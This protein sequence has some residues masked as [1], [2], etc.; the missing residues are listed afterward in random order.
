MLEKY[1]TLH[2]TNLELQ[3]NMDQLQRQLDALNAT[4]SSLE[5]QI[6]V[7]PVSIN[8]ITYIIYNLLLIIL[9]IFFCA[10]V[11]YLY[12]QDTVCI[13]CGITTLA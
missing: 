10:Y 12:S 11:E 6:C 7:S 1:N 4:K 5:D 2:Q 9:L 13:T 8:V 3:Q